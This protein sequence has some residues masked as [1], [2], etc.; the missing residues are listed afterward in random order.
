MQVRLPAS[1][2]IRPGMTELEACLLVHQAA[3]EVAGEPVQVY[4]DFVSGLRTSDKGGPPSQRVIERGDL[5]SD[6]LFGS[7][8]R[9]SRRRLQYV[10]LRRKAFGRSRA[11]CIKLAWQPSPLAQ[12]SSKP[13]DAGPERR[14][15]RAKKFCLTGSRDLLHIA[16]RSWFGAWPSGPPLLRSGKQRHAGR[17]RRRGNRTGPLFPG[18]FGMRFEHNFLVTPDGREQL[19]KHRLEIA[20][21]GRSELAI[22]ANAG[23]YFGN[24]STC[25]CQ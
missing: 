4:G 11:D 13:G 17:R 16:Q 1:R 23:N 5:V 10:C 12:S 7:N 6:G 2:K 3:A 9:L 21:A 8:S 25:L 24:V 15:G 22:R 18:Q 14:S 20:Q 19:S